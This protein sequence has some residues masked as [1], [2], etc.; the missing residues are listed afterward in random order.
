MGHE[1]MRAGDSDRQDVADKLK[2]ALNEGRLDL[3]EYD[4]RVQKAYAARTYGDL[5][6][7]LDD[8]PGTIPVQRAQVQPHHPPT[9]VQQPHAVSRGGRPGVAPAFGAFLL[10]TLI[11]AITSWTSGEAHYFWPAWVLIPVVIALLAHFSDKGKRH[12]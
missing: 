12:Q 2:I 5:D 11:W 8:L 4:E 7:L 1:G 6:G 9:P 10:C 3:N